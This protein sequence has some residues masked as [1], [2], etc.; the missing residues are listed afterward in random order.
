MM[1]VGVTIPHMSLFFPFSYVYGMW[2]GPPY[3]MAKAIYKFDQFQL[4]AAPNQV[5]WDIPV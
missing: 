5:Y 1:H 2:V 3:T 4:H